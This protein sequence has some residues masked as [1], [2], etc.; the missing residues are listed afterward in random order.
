VSLFE[1]RARALRLA[2]QACGGFTC[3]EVPVRG[4]LER[5]FRVEACQDGY[6]VLELAG[7]DGESFPVERALVEAAGLGYRGLVPFKR[8][9]R[10]V[11]PETVY[12][13]VEF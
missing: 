5:M 9:W 3:A 12:T 11:L 13:K 6:L 7:L 8:S 2:V 1:E 4:C 10:D